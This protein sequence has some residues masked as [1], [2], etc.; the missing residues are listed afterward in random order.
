MAPCLSPPRSRKARPQRQLH[1]R[2]LERRGTGGHMIGK[3]R[4]RKVTRAEVSPAGAVP[5]RGTFTTDDAWTWNFTEGRIW[6]YKVTKLQGLAEARRPHAP[7][8]TARP[9]PLPASTI[10]APQGGSFEQQK[11]GPRMGTVCR[12]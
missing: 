3:G 11:E 5:P 2:R 10:R 1:K 8:K 4:V 9:R 7:G 12:L 6:F